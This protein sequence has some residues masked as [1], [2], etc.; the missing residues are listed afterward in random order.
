MCAPAYPTTKKGL[1]Q[2]FKFRSRTKDTDVEYDF[3]DFLESATNNET[4]YAY[5][6]NVR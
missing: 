6:D 2:Q 1:N 4:K 5:Y 3:Q